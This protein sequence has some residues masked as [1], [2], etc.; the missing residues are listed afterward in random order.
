M[1][2]SPASVP[3]AS[4]PRRPRAPSCAAVHLDRAPESVAL[5]S[6][7]HRGGT[8]QALALA[9][10]VGDVGSRRRTCRARRSSAARRVTRYAPGLS[11]IC[12]CP[13]PAANICSPVWSDRTH[14]PTAESLPERGRRDA[15]R[16]LEADPL[17]RGQRE[18]REHGDR[19]DPHAVARSRRRARPRSAGGRRRRCTHAA[20]VATAHRASRP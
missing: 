17:A 16:E 15:H 10:A 2:S 14:S 20:A 13:V 6:P 18:R 19:F 9:P 5:R 12:W 7:D 11:T 8:V 1:P 3:W 4:R